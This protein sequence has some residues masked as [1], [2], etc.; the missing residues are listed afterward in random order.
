MDRIKNE[1]TR[2][3][4]KVRYLGDKV[5]EAGSKMSAGELTWRKRLKKKLQAEKGKD[6]RGDFWMR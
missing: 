3:M 5:R 1:Q 2:R 6:R 4:A